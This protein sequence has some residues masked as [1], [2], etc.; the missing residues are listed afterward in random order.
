MVTWKVSAGELDRLL[1]ILAG[2]SGCP[3][4][5]WD[6]D[7]V[8]FGLE[9]TPDGYDYA[10]YG[11]SPLQ[12]RLCPAGAGRFA[13]T[14]TA[15]PETEA[16]L[17]RIEVTSDAESWHRLRTAFREASRPERF[18]HH[19]G[20]PECEGH[21]LL[22]R[23]RNWETLTHY[24]VRDNWSPLGFLRPDGFRYWLPAVLR[25]LITADPDGHASRLP[26]Y[27][28]DPHDHRFS[29]LTPEERTAVTQFL[30]HV[31][32]WRP[33]LSDTWEGRRWFARVLAAWEG[34]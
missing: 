1:Q 26:E 12:L 32:W 21:D 31:A 8:R 25:L 28:E 24:D 14:A 15:D 30:R 27:L 9:G 18:T 3:W 23:R 20:C 34:C 11:P 16:C 5:E 7:A 33:D 17:A 29:Q 2:V 13:V 10:L 22:L 4:D 19:P 6:R